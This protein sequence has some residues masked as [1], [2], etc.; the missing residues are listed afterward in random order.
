MWYKIVFVK[1]DIIHGKHSGLSN[2]LEIILKT[3]YTPKDIGYF[4]ER[5]TNNYYLEVFDSEF[6]SK[7]IRDYNAVEC[8]KPE[9]S[10]IPLLKYP[11]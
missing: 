4:H 11:T 1:D 7:I 8:S 2:K 6:F 9:V 3:P 10:L 5:N